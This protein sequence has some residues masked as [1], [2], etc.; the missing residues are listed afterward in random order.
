VALLFS[1][2]GEKISEIPAKRRAFLKGVID[3]LGP[4]RVEQVRAELN[5]LIDELKPRDQTDRRT[6]NA[7]YLGSDLTPWSLP[8]AYLYDVA[9]TMAGENTS[10][11]EIQEQSSFSFGLFLWECMINRDDSWTVYDPNLRGDPNREVIGKTYY[12]R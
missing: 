6:V 7:S 11:E 10:E 5:R 3:E 2:E 12:E 9:V 8:L 1:L 4:E